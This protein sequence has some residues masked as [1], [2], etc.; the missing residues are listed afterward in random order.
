ML[1]EERAPS[2]VIVPEPGVLPSPGERGPSSAFGPADRSRTAL[3]CF[4]NQKRVTGRLESSVKRGSDG[5]LD[6]D[7]LGGFGMVI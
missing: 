4:W 6:C 5:S 2:S 1:S 3:R 7:F